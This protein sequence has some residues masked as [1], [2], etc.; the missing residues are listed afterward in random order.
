MRNRIAAK[1]AYLVQFISLIKR[2]NNCTTAIERKDLGNFEEEFLIGERRRRLAKVFQPTQIAFA[3]ER[4]EEITSLIKVYSRAFRTS[5]LFISL[6]R[7]RSALN[8]QMQPFQN[9]SRVFAV[10]VMMVQRFYLRIHL[11]CKQ[12]SRYIYRSQCIGT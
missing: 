10:V 9:T 3:G 4:K 11:L 12:L 2:G 7:G 6:W 8:W 1:N 5:S